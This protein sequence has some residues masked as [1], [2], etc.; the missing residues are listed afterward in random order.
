[1]G[2]KELV[3]EEDSNTDHNCHITTDQVHKVKKKKIL[4]FCIKRKK[5]QH[6]K[7]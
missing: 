7:S 5:S 1:M 6:T 4:K 2:K 3:P